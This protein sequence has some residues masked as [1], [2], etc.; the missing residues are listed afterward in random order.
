MYQCV[1]FVGIEV[2]IMVFVCNDLNIFGFVRDQLIV[3]MGVGVEIGVEG[4]VRVLDYEYRMGIDCGGQKIFV[5][6]ELV[7]VVEIDLIG[8]KNK[9]YFVFVDFWIGI[10]CLFDLEYVIFFL[11]ID[12]L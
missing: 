12:I 1:V 8:V 6:V 7:F 10:D 3:L 4:V 9:F 5:V 2:L 11:V